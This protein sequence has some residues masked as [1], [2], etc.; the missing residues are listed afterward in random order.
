MYHSIRQFMINNFIDLFIKV[1]EEDLLNELPAS[2]REEVLYRQYGGLVETIEI[3]R[4][5]NDNEFVWTI[6]QIASK[7]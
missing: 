7:I 3:L 5:S 2:L 6:I 1:D 4:V